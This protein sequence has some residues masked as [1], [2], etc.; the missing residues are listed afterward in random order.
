MYVVI[1]QSRNIYRPV[2]GRS[3]G[4]LDTLF[5]RSF[6]SFQTLL[7]LPQQYIHNYIPIQLLYC[8]FIEYSAVC[9]PIHLVYSTNIFAGEE[10][11]MSAW[12]MAK[13]LTLPQ[14]KLWLSSIIR[15]VRALKE[16]YDSIIV[17]QY[18]IGLFL[19]KYLLELLENR[20]RF[21]HY[22]S[23]LFFSKISSI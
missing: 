16:I 8:R 1:Q 13:A 20:N 18:L 12:T 3:D 6:Q 23:A 21:G 14:V 2:D 22:S 4:I 10:E 19:L 7:L 11:G 15:G 5:R 9:H 17:T